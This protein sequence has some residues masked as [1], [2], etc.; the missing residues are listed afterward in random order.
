MLTFRFIPFIFFHSSIFLSCT[1]H[2]P[3][4]CS[5]NLTINKMGAQNLSIPA[6]EWMYFSLSPRKCTWQQNGLG[7]LWRYRLNFCLMW[8]CKHVCLHVWVHVEEASS[9]SWESLSQLLFQLTYGD[10]VSHCIRDSPFPLQLNWLD[11]KPSWGIFL[12][13]PTPALLQQQGYRHPLPQLAF[14]WALWIWI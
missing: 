9:W 14:K 11:S 12:L 5:E 4:S 2:R 3:C 13:P 10:T 6:F 7:V 1:H 8:W